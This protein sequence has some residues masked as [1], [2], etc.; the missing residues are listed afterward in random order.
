MGEFR[1]HILDDA[2][3]ETELK[4]L[5]RAIIPEIAA[6][7]AKIMSNKDLV[8]AGGKDSQ[9]HAL[10]QHDGRARRA[11]AFAFSRIIPPTTSAASCW[12]RSMVCSTAAAMRSSA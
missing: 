2:T 6:A 1:E 3:G 7:V 9:R 12:P 4:T 10:P 5:Q 11:R 8:L